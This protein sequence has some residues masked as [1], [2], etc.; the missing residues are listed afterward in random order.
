MSIFRRVFS[1]QLAAEES[2]KQPPRDVPD[3]GVPANA[4]PASRPV[5]V[6]SDEPPRAEGA[7]ADDHAA[8][9]SPTGDQTPDS[10][11]ARAAEANRLM[12]KA[13][14]AVKPTPPVAVADPAPVAP[15]AAVPAA[16]QVPAAP[17]AA[18]PPAPAADPAHAMPA[19]RR[20]RTRILG[21]DQGDDDIGDPIA[22]AG[23]AVQNRAFP[24]GWIVITDGP[25]RGQFFPLFAG[26]AM[27]GRGEDQ[28]I[29]LD[30]GDMAISRQNHAAL[31]YDPEDNKFYIGH[32]GKSNIIRLNGRPVL[33]TEE[34]SH[35]D[36]LRIGE[37][38]LR[39]VAL[40]GGNFRWAVTA[41]E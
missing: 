34:L 12:Q 8:A 17:P 13:R 27:I 23:E 32:G 33:A 2:A 4:A 29:P 16:P 31:A 9:A 1:D 3:S 30:F 36:T 11:M 38:T 25:G 22:K 5:L 21:F 14:P 37:T 10:L 41:D 15:M 6:V 24:T 18:P 39:F 35:D 7:G 26:V 40:C 28:A 20:T 19:R